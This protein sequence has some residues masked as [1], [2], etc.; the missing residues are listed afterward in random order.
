MISFQATFENAKVSDEEPSMI[1]EF[2][3][4]FKKEANKVGTSRA[5]MFSITLKLINWREKRHLGRICN[6]AQSSSA[7][8]LPEAASNFLCAYANPLAIHNAADNL[9]NNSHHF[10]EEKF[11]FSERIKDAA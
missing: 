5:Q 8:F 9:R 6:N 3:T 11:T 4:K 7:I 2:R 1:L 10:R